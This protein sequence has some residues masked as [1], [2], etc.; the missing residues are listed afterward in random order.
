MMNKLE[1]TMRD[2]VTDIQT[3]DGVP[4]KELSTYEEVFDW[5]EN[6]FLDSF[7]PEERWYNGDRVDDEETGFLVLYNKKLSGFVLKQRRVAV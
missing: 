3:S 6:G 7:F 5:L 4:F 1:N 2:F